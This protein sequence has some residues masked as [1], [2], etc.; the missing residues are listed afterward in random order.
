MLVFA[1]ALTSKTAILLADFI[2]ED[3]FALFGYISYTPQDNGGE[4][5]NGVAKRLA[6]R[7]GMKQRFTKPYSPQTNGLDGKMNGVIADRLAKLV[8]GKKKD[9]PSKLPDAPCAMRTS[10][11]TATGF[12]PA[13]LVLGRDIATPLYVEMHGAPPVNEREL[14]TQAEEE[15]ENMKNSE[16]VE[17]GQR[18]L[19]KHYQK[20]VSSKVTG[21]RI[22]SAPLRRRM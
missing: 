15:R 19:E 9:W 20:I 13:S 12:A 18:I 16:G 11:S 14:E 10:I 22:G 8:D 5:K 17:R 6:D 21:E 1:R 4:F 2:Y 7:L 3:I